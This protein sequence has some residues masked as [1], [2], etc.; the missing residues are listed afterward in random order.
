MSSVAVIASSRKSI[1][2]G[3]PEL[4]RALQR[5]GVAD[6]IWREVTRSREAPE[7]VR[8]A[9]NDGAKLVFVWGGDGMIQR[10][11]G[12]LANTN[13]AL[14]IVPAG[15]ANLLASNL[16]IPRDIDAAVAIG[17]RGRH[18]ALDVGRINGE[19]FAVMAGAGFDAHMV[20]DADGRL[21]RWIGRSAY[22]WSGLK[23]IRAKPFRAR[24]EV[25]GR[26]WYEGKA[27][28]I[29]IGNVGHLFAGVEVFHNAQTD[30]GLLEVGVLTADGLLEW[31]RVL[32][33]TAFG[34]ASDSPFVRVTKGRSIRMKL[35]PKVLYELDGGSRRKE[36]AFN[37]EVEPR[38][39]TVCVPK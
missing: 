17:L 12:A 34:K 3:L 25:D 5:Q 1:A 2:G 27:S 30:D 37:V 10:C 24:I 8:R 18:R 21:K 39:V 9:L 16:G 22:I 6:P 29:L 15:T 7:Q 28:C 11:V 26:R 19:P 4:R 32:S 38:A 33:R 20:R 31:G 14:A 36:K 13:A 35:K 23:N